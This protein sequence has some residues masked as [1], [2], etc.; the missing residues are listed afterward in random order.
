M[1]NSNIRK[2]IADILYDAFDDKI[3]Y[4]WFLTSDK[5]KS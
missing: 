4:F 2:Q 1:T 5:E 3:R